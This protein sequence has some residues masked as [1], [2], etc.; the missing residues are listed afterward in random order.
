MESNVTPQ[1]R[2]AAEPTVGRCGR[3]RSHGDGPY[4]APR[5]RSVL[6]SVSN[7][8]HTDTSL[9]NLR[10]FMQTVYQYGRERQEVLG[11]KAGTA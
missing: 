8:I 5:Y 2:R 1:P 9:E 3:P 6:A 10:A 4:A 11:A 7:A